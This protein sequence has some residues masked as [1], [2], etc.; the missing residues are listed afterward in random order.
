[1]KNDTDIETMQKEVMSVIEQAERKKNDTEK[2]DIE[3]KKRLDTSHL[4][5]L[6]FNRTWK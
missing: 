6:L 2:G 5:G 1:M 3:K 4:E